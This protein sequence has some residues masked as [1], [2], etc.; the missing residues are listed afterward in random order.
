MARDASAPLEFEFVADPH[1]P[2][3]TV[4]CIKAII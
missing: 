2:D 1:N 4:F 3:T